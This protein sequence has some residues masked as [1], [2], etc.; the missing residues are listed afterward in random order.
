M[1]TALYQPPFRDPARVLL[2]LK[3]NKDGTVDL[4]RKQDEGDGFILEIGKCPVS[5]ARAVGHCVIGTAEQLAAEA[6]KASAEA[7]ETGGVAAE[8]APEPAAE[9]P[10]ET[11]RR[12][13]R[14]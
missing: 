3:E 4:G 2:V 14:A 9:Q 6:E 12:S 13:R 11:P 7:Q 10:A 1:K 8:A 5:K